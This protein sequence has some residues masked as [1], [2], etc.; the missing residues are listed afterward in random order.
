M[1]I[2]SIIALALFACAVGLSFP[3]RCHFGRLWYDEPNAISNANRLREV[4]Q[5]F[6]MIIYL[7]R[8]NRN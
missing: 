2:K 8:S 4:R 1:K 5:P 6:N 7:V 3:M